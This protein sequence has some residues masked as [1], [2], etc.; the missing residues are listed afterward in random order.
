MADQ[1]NINITEA[2]FG[3]LPTTLAATEWLNAAIIDG[4]SLVTSRN[5]REVA[6]VGQVSDSDKFADGMTIQTSALRAVDGERRFVVTQNSH[7]LLGWPARISLASDAGY[8]WPPVLSL[9]AAINWGIAVSNALA[10]TGE[11][12]LP[13]ELCR[14]LA[15]AVH[16]DGDWEERRAVCKMIGDVLFRAGRKSVAAAWRLLATDLR[17][18]KERH[19]SY[20]SLAVCTQQADRSFDQEST[21][22]QVIAEGGWRVLAEMDDVRVGELLHQ[23]VLLD[24]PILAAREVALR[25]LRHGAEPK[26]DKVDLDGKFG[27][28]PNS[29]I[30]SPTSVVVLKAVGGT[31]TSWTDR[32]VKRAVADIL[33]KPLPLVAPPDVTAARQTLLDEF[34]YASVAIDAILSDL[35]GAQFVCIR[36]TLLAGPAGCGKSRLARRIGETTGLYV[37]RYDGAG[38]SD[39]AWGGTARR[40]STGEPTVPVLAMIAA[41]SANALVLVDELDKSATAGDNGRLQDA[42]LPHLETETSAQYPDPYIQAPVDCSYLSY[43]ATANDPA[44]IRGP[45]RDR[46]RLLRV[47][48]PTQEDLPALTRGIARDLAK[49]SGIDP[50]W[51]PNLDA[52]ELWIAARLWKT[53]SIRQLREI[54]ARIVAKRADRPRH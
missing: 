37:H 44:L 4:W 13:D 3:K 15:A 6:I 19:Q 2:L 33:N 11:H 8:I 22:D 12:T 20:T 32:E 38:A 48:A 17:S 9:A 30:G 31:A 41:K 7:Y 26:A 1:C 24:D 51:Y 46:F 54:V 53:G 45:L 34:P 23:G 28:L 36:P 14:A 10:R 42:M 47:P 43:I 29:N 25:I 52:G 27:N 5:E 21:V 50:A 18:A 35:A 49:S 40:W 39:N 16:D